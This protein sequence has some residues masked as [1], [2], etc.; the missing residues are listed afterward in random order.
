[1]GGYKLTFYG[2][3]SASISN[4][5]TSKLH[6][7]GVLLIPGSRYMFL[8]VKNFYLNNPVTK[9][10]YCKVSIS[11]ILQDSIDNYNLM[12]KKIYCLLYVKA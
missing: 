4:I 1:M 11:L 5:T 2:P 12:E 7:N 6:W 8:D 3:V 10:E 9:P